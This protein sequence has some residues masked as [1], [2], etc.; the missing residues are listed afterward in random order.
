M[1]S[2]WGIQCQRIGKR[3]P[4]PSCPQPDAPLGHAVQYPLTPICYWGTLNQ[5]RGEVCRDA[6]GVYWCDGKRFSHLQLAFD[7]AEAV[8][9]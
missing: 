1:V 9:D 2:S 3:E 4:V 7:Y 6:L 5:R 8:H